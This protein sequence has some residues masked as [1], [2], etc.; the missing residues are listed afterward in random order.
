MARLASESTVY[1]HYW[2]H[3]GAMVSSDGYHPYL[4]DRAEIVKVYP[5]EVKGA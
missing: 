4:I 3:E 2:T 1:L 5:M